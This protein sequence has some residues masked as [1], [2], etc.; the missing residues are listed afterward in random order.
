MTQIRV[1]EGLTSEEVA[2]VL[3]LVR[4]ATEEDGV[5]PLSEHVMLHL[6][7]GGDRQARNVMLMEDGKVAGYAHLDPTD[8]VEGPSGELV[9]HPAYRRRHLG[10]TLVQALAK[11]AGP[12]PLRLWAHGDLPAA[13]RL[14]A[15]AG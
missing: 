9:I 8:P 12:H 11:E 3:E 4:L 10:L 7:Y 15:A 1:A 2:A 5:A 14:A 13:T 6:R